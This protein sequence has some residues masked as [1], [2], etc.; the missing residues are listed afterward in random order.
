MCCDQPGD[1]PPS[2]CGPQACVNHACYPAWLATK[3]NCCETSQQCNDGDPA[4][5]DACPKPGGTCTHT[6][7]PGLCIEKNG[8]AAVACNDSNPCTF[9]YCLNGYCR[10]TKP[11]PGC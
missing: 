11:I 2:P 7:I 5:Q 8:D 6:L 3:P 10:H 4:T 1:C 9:D